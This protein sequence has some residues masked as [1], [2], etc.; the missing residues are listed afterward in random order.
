DPY[1]SSYDPEWYRVYVLLSNAEKGVLELG[2]SY[3]T[4]GAVKDPI[5]WTEDVT[6]DGH[7]DLIVEIDDP[8]EYGVAVMRGR[9]DGTFHEGAPVDLGPDLPSYNARALID[10]DGD[11]TREWIVTVV[12]GRPWVIPFDFSKE[13]IAPMVAL[14]D[15][16]AGGSTRFKEAVGDINGDGVDD[17]RVRAAYSGRYRGEFLMIS[18]P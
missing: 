12:E 4:G 14:N 1:P 9:G 18:A 6:G 17:Y 7:L 2:G 16:E 10:V 3:P 5:L 8:L 11:G 13:G 15:P